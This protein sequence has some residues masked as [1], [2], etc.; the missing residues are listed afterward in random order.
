MQLVLSMR[1]SSNSIVVWA[2]VF[3]AS[4]VGVVGLRL[5][6]WKYR[7]N[8]IR[9]RESK[10]LD[11]IFEEYFADIGIS[12]QSFLRVWT[13]IGQAYRIDPRKLRPEDRFDEE[14]RKLELWT[15]DEAI[16]V[17]E[18]E[19]KRQEIDATR[20]TRVRSIGDFVRLCCAASDVGK[21]IPPGA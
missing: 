1:S 19:L 18:D 15:A 11:S 2:I 21:A 14:L 16:M 20:T 4:F 13:L 9:D 17:L 7:R 8:L 10:D 5:M 6:S 3:G 12:R